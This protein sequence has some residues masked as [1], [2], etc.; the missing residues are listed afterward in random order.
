MNDLSVINALKSADYMSKRHMGWHVVHPKLNRFIY[1]YTSINPNDAKSMAQLEDIICESKFLLSSPEDFNDPFDCPVYIQISN[2]KN[3]RGKLDQLIR[4]YQPEMRGLKRKTVINQL[5]TANANK[6]QDFARAA[7]L[8]TRNELGITC[9]SSEPRNL[10]MWSHYAYKHTGICFQF[11]VMKDFDNFSKA[12]PVKY[13]TE[14]PVFD[15]FK[16]TKKDVLNTVLNKYQD[17]AYENECRIIVPDGVHKWYT[18]SPRALTRILIGS[19]TS[20]EQISKLQEILELR[21]KAGLPKI[22][23]LKAKQHLDSYKISFYSLN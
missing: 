6:W 21:S 14:Y 11:E 23:L 22:K 7:V 15:F 12:I 20:D 17:W 8:K 5:M 13:V 10:L 16:D 18:F 2:I 1:K 9:F 19:R 4:E 3:I